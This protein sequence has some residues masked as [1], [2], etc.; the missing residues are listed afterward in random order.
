MYNG[1]KNW[2][3]WNVALWLSGDPHLYFAAKAWLAAAGGNK[4]RAARGLYHALTHADFGTPTPQTPDGARYS[5]TAIRAALRG[6]F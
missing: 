6:K 1:H 2:T 3:H 4:D 5:V